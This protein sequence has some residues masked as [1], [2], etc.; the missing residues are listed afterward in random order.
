[1]KISLFGAGYVGLVSAACFSELGNEVL[2]CDIDAAKIATLRQGRCPIYE[3]GLEAMIKR[4]LDDGR[5]RFTTDSAETVTHGAVIFIAVGTPDNDLEPVLAVAETIGANLSSPG[6]IIVNKSTVPVGSVEKVRATITSALKKRRLNQHFSVVANPEFL[7]EGEAI[8]DFLK[9]DRVVVGVEDPEAEKV[10]RSLYQPLTKNGHPILIMSPASAEMAKYAANGLLATKISFINH[11]ARLCEHLGADVEEVRR[12][13]GADK[14]IGP[15]FL[16]SGIGYGGSCFPK[17]AR[18]LIALAAEKGE[19]PD[20]MNAVEKINAEQKTL[21]ARK[22]IRQIGDTKKSDPLR[23]K[24]IAVW[25]LA[26]KPHTDDTRNAPAIAVINELLAAGAEVS[27]FD[28]VVS[29]K[30][31]AAVFGENAVHHAPDMY[32]AAKGSDALALITEW[33]Q[34]KNPDWQKL[35][36]LMRN[37]LIADGRNIYD[38]ETLKESGF[39]YLGIGRCGASSTSSRSRS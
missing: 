11:V 6:K 12:A 30:K 36:T 9:P 18:A 23:G 1:M 38:G 32:A 2:C 8:S 25:G 34:F 15:Y 26:F 3:P 28:P 39:A 31:T 37:P 17:D 4:N 13:I 14:R 21:L 24:K 19:S 35:H 7:K 16:Y 33:P 10:M 5:L 27:L 29:K 22:I 20:L